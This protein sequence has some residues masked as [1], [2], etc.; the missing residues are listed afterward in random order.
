MKVQPGRLS[1]AVGR[2]AEPV[3]DFNPRRMKISRGKPNFLRDQLGLD[4][5]PNEVGDLILLTYEVG[6]AGREELRM[7]TVESEV[8]DQHQ[9]VQGSVNLIIGDDELL[10]RNKRLV[11]FHTAKRNPV[12]GN[13]G[14]GGHRFHLHVFDV[15]TERFVT[16]STDSDYASDAA[17]ELDDD[18]ISWNAIRSSTYTRNS[19]QCEAGPG[20]V[21]RFQPYNDQSGFDEVQFRVQ[22][23]VAVT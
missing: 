18:G 5:V 2:L 19:W 13:R 10:H 17:Y 3:E 22:A 23:I 20:H 12:S 9:N 21:F 14:A 6:N 1:G 15:E 8:Y 4:A 7:I 11:S 16:V